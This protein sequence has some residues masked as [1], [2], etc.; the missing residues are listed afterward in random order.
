M[1]AAERISRWAR[2]FV[3]VGAGW[4][5][6]WQGAVLA[7]VGHRTGVVLGVLGFAFQTIFG[8]AY[9]LVPSYFDRSL[10]TTRFMPVHLLL[11]SLGPALLAV[12]IETARPALRSAG[13]AAWGLAVGLFV[14]TIGLTIRDNPLGSE[15]GTGEAS[16]HREPLDRTANLF[17]PVVLGYLLVGSYGLLAIESGLPPLLDGYPPRTSHLLAAG[18]GAL[19]IFTI[20]FRLLPRF[21]VANVERELALIVLAAGALGPVTVAI[22]LP[23]GQ[24]FV[25]GAVL[26]A[27]AVIGYAGAVAVLFA[28]SDR[29]RVGLYGA[30]AGAG[31]GTLA[32]LIGLLFAFDGVTTARIAAHTRLNLLGLLGLTI[33]G[34]S[35][36]F[37]PPGV[38]SLPLIDD[39]TALLAL[40][41]LGGGVLAEAGGLLAGLE[42]VRAGG[43]ALAAGG[44]VVHLVVIGT[45]IAER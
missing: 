34:V 15:T 21:F 7:G 22:S 45:V 37:Y 33:V 1:T 29:R 25:V 14:G 43:R 12:G 16:G 44:A 6:I 42:S 5:A 41:L 13:A 17:F 4:L 39:R 3:L 36:Q 28:R 27:T 11:A 38:S 18:G 31:A 26:E 2:R 19:L 40:A 24:L 20:G 8:K 35:Y 9:S 32:A 30:L 10:A 23:A